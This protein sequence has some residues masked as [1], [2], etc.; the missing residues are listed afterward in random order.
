MKLK[1]SV[2]YRMKDIRKSI[3]IF[4]LIVIAS[5]IFTAFLNSLESIHMSQFGGIEIGSMIFLFIVS[6]NSFK[7]AF[8][9]LMQHGVSR[10]TMFN[11]FIISAIIASGVMALIDSI[12]YTLLGTGKS[13]NTMF[14]QVYTG[15]YD[16]NLLIKVLVTFVWALSAY[17]AFSMA[18][19]FISVLYYRMNK[20]LKLI[21][22]IT[23]PSFIF[24]IMP[25]IDVYFGWN[26][27]RWI[28]K[29]FELMLGTGENMNPFRSVITC[30]ILSII[31][32][33]LS[34]G[35]VKKAVVKRN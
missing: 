13:V 12:C 30:S 15:L 31:G 10:K 7:P 25:A 6:M 28:G 20:T 29:A 18:G 17:L 14:E 21:V 11:S 35:L 1:Q 26:I 27:T 4:Y 3:L 8:Y 24:I 23:V 19:Y 33:L 9:L 34:Y 16:D 5:Y 32:A 2:V 22:S